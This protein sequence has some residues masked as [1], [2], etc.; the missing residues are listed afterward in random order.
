MIENIILS[1]TRCGFNDRI[2]NIKGSDKQKSAVSALLA[3]RK[4]GNLEYEATYH[5]ELQY[6]MH[7]SEV[8]PETRPN[9][10]Q[11]CDGVLVADLNGT[12]AAVVRDVGNKIAEV[13][14]LW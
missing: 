1:C 13:L 11:A 9:S 8:P 6:C 14:K 2:G 7:Q 3:K 4:R 10:F 5:W 12:A